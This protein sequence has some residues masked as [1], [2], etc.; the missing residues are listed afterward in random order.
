MF[1]IKGFS[2]EAVQII[3]LAIK[4]AI[5]MCHDHVGGEH[6]LLAITMSSQ[7]RGAALLSA[8]GLGVVGVTEKISQRHPIGSKKLKLTPDSFDEDTKKLLLAAITFAAEQGRVEATPVDIMAALLSDKQACGAKLLSECGMDIDNLY[9]TLMLGRLSNEVNRTKRPTALSRFGVDMVRTALVKGYDPCIGREDELNTLMCIL[10]R[11]SKNNACLVGP[12]GVGK[13]AIAEELAMRIAIG[14]APEPLKS[15]RLIAITSAELV[16]GTKYRGDFEERITAIINEVVAAGDIILFV[17]ELHSLLSA[18]GAEG[19]V[20]ASSILKPTLA[21]GELQLLGATTEDEYRRYIE[22]DSAFERRFAPVK[23]E[24]PT[25]EQALVIVE[26]AAHR[27]SEF[28]G[29]EFKEEALQAAVELSRLYIPSRHLPDKAIDLIDEAASYDRIFAKKGIVEREDIIRII[30]KKT[31]LSQLNN[32]TLL[33]EIND[34]FFGN[35]EE[36]LKLCRAMRRYAMGFSH[37]KRPAASFIIVGP[38]GVGKTRLANVLAKA[39]FSDSRFLSLDL[40]Q[41]THCSSLIG[42]AAGYIGHE[43]AGVLTEFV[44]QNPSCILLLEGIDR[45]VPEVQQLI[46]SI[47][48]EGRILDNNSLTVSFQSSVMILT[49]NSSQNINNLG[50]E[51]SEKKISLP[52]GYSSAVDEIITLKRP[53]LDLMIKIVSADI[54]ESLKMLHKGGII[55][56]VSKNLILE[57]ANDLVARREGASLL[58]GTIKNRLLDPLC[59][60]LPNGSGFYKIEFINNELKITKEQEP[61][62]LPKPLMMQS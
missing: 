11:R 12:A 30:D 58:K 47:L 23:I 7:S 50:F 61:S 51:G 54:E 10:C 42:A 26:G 55:C 9:R 49:V 57:I 56:T 38:D 16:A 41:Y 45:A 60:Q 25:I 29:V 52:S 6:I 20:D 2:K 32:S 19:A 36:V 62:Q 40:S 37:E 18:G 28:H 46:L 44:R 3:N 5:D 27:Y 48:K 14:R 15:K 8:H 22:K 39:M 59:E 4:Q 35:D 1:I 53:N 13:T 34:K 43:K 33:Q 24:E 17:D 31:G 21:R